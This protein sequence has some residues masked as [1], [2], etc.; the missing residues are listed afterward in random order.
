MGRKTQ[1]LAAAVRGHV[2]EVQRFIDMGIFNDKPT[3]D[4]CLH[5]VVTYVQP[6]VLRVLLKNGIDANSHTYGASLLVSVTRMID[7]EGILLNMM[8][9]L[10]QH[11][12]SV[13]SIGDDVLT[14]LYWAVLLKKRLAVDLLIRHGAPIDVIIPYSMT[15]TMLH[16]ACYHSNHKCIQ[17]LVEA[18]ADLTIR[19]ALDETA[20]DV[21]VRVGNQLG[22]ELLSIEI[23]FRIQNCRAAILMFMLIRHKRADRCGAFGRID[24]HLV[25]IIAQLVWESRRQLV[26]TS[27]NSKWRL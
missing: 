8:E 18:G 23:P 6:E 11:G 12:A 2:A 26:W 7:D 13:S 21:A 10:L 19:N 14:P 9:M 22:A 20:L 17:M 25:K 3:V 16:L 5:V 24:K 4:M 15:P 1:A 27:S